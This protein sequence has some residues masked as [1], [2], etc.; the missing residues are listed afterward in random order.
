MTVVGGVVGLGAAVGLGRLAQSLLYQMRGWDPLVL[1][2]A[3]V[4]LAI[5]ALAAGFIPAHRASQVDPMSAL[6][7]E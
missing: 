7:Y 1:T 2:M 3:G 4:S 6:R 5:V